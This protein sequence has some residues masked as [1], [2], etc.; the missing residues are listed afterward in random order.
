MFLYIANEAVRNLRPGV[1]NATR[2]SRFKSVMKI[3]WKNTKLDWEQNY[4]N[5]RFVRRDFIT[6]LT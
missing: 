5:V 1:K 2:S 4:S 3:T 6:E